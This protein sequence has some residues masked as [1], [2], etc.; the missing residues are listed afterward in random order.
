[1][2]SNEM[3]RTQDVPNIT[4]VINNKEIDDVDDDENQAIVIKPPQIQARV[5]N[6]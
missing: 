4:R 1:M 6:G 2:N 5:V 3:Y